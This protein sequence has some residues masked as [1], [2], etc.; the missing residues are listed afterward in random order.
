MIAVMTP[1]TQPQTHSQPAAP[2]CIAIVGSRRRTD[3]DTVAA[4][5][6]TLPPGTLVVSGGAPGPDQWAAEAAAARPDLPPALVLR[7]DDSPK[8]RWRGE[9]ARR[10][11]ERN[12]RIVAEADVVYALVAADRRGGTENTIRHARKAG[13]PVHLL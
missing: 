2:R 7:P 4:L 12:A 10:L 9:A 8:P 1:A 13:K 11:N 3:R 5:V 6:A